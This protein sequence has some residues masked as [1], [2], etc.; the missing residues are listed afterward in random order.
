MN[1]N[2]DSYSDSKILLMRELSEDT[3]EVVKVTALPEARARYLHTTIFC[4]E[5]L[6][7]PGARNFLDRIMHWFEMEEIATFT[8]D[9]ESFDCALLA[10]LIAETLYDGIEMP[11]EDALKMVRHITGIQY[12]EI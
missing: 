9:N 11:P 5:Y 2:W 12:Y 10:S 3:F 8:S 7:T 4:R 6:D 1:K